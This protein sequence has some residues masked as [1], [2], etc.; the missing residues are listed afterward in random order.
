[1]A[2]AY[3]QHFLKDDKVSSGAAASRVADAG[4]MEAAVDAS[5]LDEGLSVE[6][7]DGIE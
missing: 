2:S 7:E 6:A 1:V 3:D 5:H 4:D